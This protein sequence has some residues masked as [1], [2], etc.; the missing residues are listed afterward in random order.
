MT[1]NEGE[2][3]KTEKTEIED[4]KLSQMEDE[5]KRAMSMGQFSFVGEKD[6]EVLDDSEALIECVREWKGA[7]RD[8]RK[9]VRIQYE[10]AES[11]SEDSPPLRWTKGYKSVILPRRSDSFAIVWVTSKGRVVVDQDVVLLSMDDVIGV[12]EDHQDMSGPRGARFGFTPSGSESDDGEL[13]FDPDLFWSVGFLYKHFKTCGLMKW[14]KQMAAMRREIKAKASKDGENRAKRKGSRGLKGKY[15]GKLTGWKGT[16]GFVQCTSGDFNGKTVFLHHSDISSPYLRLSRGL[17][18]RFD[19]VRDQEDGQ[20][21]RAVKAQLCICQYTCGVCEAPTPQRKKQP[22]QQNRLRRRS[23][24]ASSSSSAAAAAANA[25]KRNSAGEDSASRSGGET[26]SPRSKT[27][28]TEETSGSGG[29]SHSDST[30]GSGNAR[31]GK[32]RRQFNRKQRK[33]E[34]GDVVAED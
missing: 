23:S 4:R 16:Y 21:L 32:G 14:D 17:E 33:S 31:R 13:I 27:E 24:K 9:R 7:N 20:K 5:R 6:K 29:R 34:A 1:I 11:T 10:S 12:K 8:D 22:N 26:G 30:P 2:T 18:M 28:V 19:I 25:G 15:E 3:E